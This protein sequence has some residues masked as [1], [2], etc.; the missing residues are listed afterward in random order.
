[1]VCKVTVTFFR[2]MTGYFLN[3]SRIARNRSWLL[4]VFPDAKIINASIWC[5]RTT[6]I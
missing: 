6:A 4:V 2:D 1:M 5:T 3:G